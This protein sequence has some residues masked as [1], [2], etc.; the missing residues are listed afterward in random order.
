MHDNAKPR[1]VRT[2]MHQMKFFILSGPPG[3]GKTAILN[4]MNGVHAR[5]DEPARRVLA[6]QRARGGT[7][8]GEQNADEFVK[9]M[10]I[11]ACEDYRSGLS[12]GNGIV[13]FDRGVPD[14]LGFS[15]YYRL[16]ASR[17]RLAAQ[18]FRYGRDVFWLPAWRKIYRQDD[19]RRLEE[20]VVD[21]PVEVDRVLIGARDRDADGEWC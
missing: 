12:Y 7:A 14:L 20:A 19:E 10:A 9:R 18:R 8:T 1:S 3:A 4:E 6:A 11:M 17:L 2:N 15:A 13:I 5:I 16:P 21:R